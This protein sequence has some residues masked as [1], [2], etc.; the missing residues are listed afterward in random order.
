[1]HPYTIVP[2]EYYEVLLPMP[3][4]FPHVNPAE[5]Q[6]SGK[7]NINQETWNMKVTFNEPRK[8]AMP[9]GKLCRLIPDIEKHWLNA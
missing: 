4:W 5:K 6:H 7:D 3:S 9:S 8:T 2:L 1:M